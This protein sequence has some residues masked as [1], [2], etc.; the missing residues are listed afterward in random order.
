MIA[1]S[2]A[3]PSLLTH[4]QPLTPPLTNPCNSTHKEG[5]VE[6]MTVGLAGLGQVKKQQCSPVP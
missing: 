1:Q 4:T 6:E 2:N 5:G 3:L